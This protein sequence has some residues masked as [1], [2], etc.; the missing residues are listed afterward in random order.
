MT[1]LHT[2]KMLINMHNFLNTLLEKFIHTATNALSPLLGVQVPTFHKPPV[3]EKGGALWVPV[4]L[5]SAHKESPSWAHTA[6]PP[7]AAS[8]HTRL[9]LEGQLLWPTQQSRL[10]TVDCLFSCFRRISLIWGEVRGILWFS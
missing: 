6:L 7:S 8:L 9:L 10:S 2:Y 4:L 1:T 5:P 3:G